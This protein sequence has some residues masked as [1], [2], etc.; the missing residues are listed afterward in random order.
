[1]DEENLERLSNDLRNRS[2]AAVVLESGL[3]LVLTFTA[4]LGNLLVV[5]LVCRN[6][7][8]R[9]VTNMFLVGL[10][11]ADFLTSSLV[12]PFTASILIHGKWV[13]SKDVCVFQGVSILCLVWSSLHMVTLIAINRYVCVLKASLYRKWFTKKNTGAMIATVSII[14]FILAISPYW[15]GLVT[16]IFRPGKAACFM[17]FDTKRKLGKIAYTV[18]LLAIYTVL[19]MVLIAV[20]YYNVFRMVKQ[21]AIATKNTIRSRAQHAS[22]L[23]LEEIRMTKLLLVLVVAFVI[24]WAPVIAIDFLNAIMG[25]GSLPREAYVTYILFA[26]GSSCINPIVCLTLNV[27]I[28]REAKKIILFKRL[29]HVEDT[30]VTKESKP[31]L[32]IRGLKATAGEDYGISTGIG[33]AELQDMSHM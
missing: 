7:R 3:A 27:K 10:A 32:T 19:P 5:Y 16:Y 13:F 4:F 20:C 25:T 1:M 14:S 30:E 12:M 23:S 6:R 9:T 21:H 11:V 15:S 28:R 24:C 2:K 8:L 33:T 17:T 29:R 18:F 26:F 31:E 22:N